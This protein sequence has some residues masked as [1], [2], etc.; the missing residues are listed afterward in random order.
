MKLCEMAIN[1]DIAELTCD[2]CLG[3]NEIETIRSVQLFDKLEF[4]IKLRRLLRHQSDLRFEQAA[5][6]FG[7]W[8]LARTRW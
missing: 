5:D 1:P 8:Q 6:S 3:Q 4:A 2:I 7:Q